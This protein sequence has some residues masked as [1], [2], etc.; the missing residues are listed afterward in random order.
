MLNKYPSNSH[1]DRTVLLVR[2]VLSSIYVK[3]EVPKDALAKV[4]GRRGT[5]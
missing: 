3:A 4:I 2:V 1:R 5:M